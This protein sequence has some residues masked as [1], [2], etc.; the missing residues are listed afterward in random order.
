MKK[1]TLLITLLCLITIDSFSN[2]QV[3][4]EK[5][6]EIIVQIFNDLDYIVTNSYTKHIF[7]ERCHETAFNSIINGEVII[8]YDTTLAYN[9]S[10]CSSVSINQDNSVIQLGI[11]KFIV[12]KYK[13]F[14]T[15]IHAIIMH[16]LQHITDIKTNPIKIAL[17]EKG[18]LIEKFYF[19]VDALVI[20]GLFLKHYVEPYQTLTPFE[21]FLAS[22][23]ERGMINV[24]NLF[25]CTDLELTHK[26]DDISSSNLSKKWAVKALEKIG[27]D[28]LKKNRIN[29]S[30]EEWVRYANFTMHNTYIKF[31]KQALYDIATKKFKKSEI[32]S[33]YKIEDYP[34]I[35]KV[36]EDIKEHLNNN[37]ELLQYRQRV[38]DKFESFYI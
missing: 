26:M 36:I 32:G 25:V 14:P 24:V 28:L 23:L 22:D 6:E 38:I 13:L 16:E 11:G 17:S 4:T 35:I 37:I 9:L 15:L 8:Y 5:P 34:E 3:K 18:N 20:E 21:A 27:R 30:D 19:E 29:D 7:V 33:E 12:E 1:L 10:G 31:C 2:N